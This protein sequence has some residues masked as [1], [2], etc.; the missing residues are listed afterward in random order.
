MPGA[1]VRKPP[2]KEP[3]GR[4]VLR[5]PRALWRF[6][7]Q[8]WECVA[9]PRGREP[10]ST[11][12]ES[13]SAAPGSAPAASDGGD[14]GSV[15]VCAGRFARA[16]LQ[17]LQEVARRHVF[18]HAPAQWADGR[19]GHRGAPVSRG[20]LRTPRSSG[21]HRPVTITHSADDSVAH[22]EPRPARSALPRERVR[23][24]VLS[25][26]DAEVRS[27]GKADLYG[28]SLRHSA[29]KTTARSRRRL[30]SSLSSNEF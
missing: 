20:R 1:G 19:L 15:C 22:P 29:A 12:L 11:A 6:G 14:R 24:V 23:P 30:L 21:Q 18:D 3:A 27:V 25:G 13:M 9:A 17:P 5:V 10:G 4:R 2:G 16:S 7:P 26:S 8:G 28:A